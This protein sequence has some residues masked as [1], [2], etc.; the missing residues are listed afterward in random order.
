MTKNYVVIALF[1]L[2]VAKLTFAQSQ[3]STNFKKQLLGVR[4]K[5]Y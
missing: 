4:Y 2:F 3:N 5:D 1:S